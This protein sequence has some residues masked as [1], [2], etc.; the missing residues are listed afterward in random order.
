MGSGVLALFVVRSRRAPRAFEGPVVSVVGHTLSGSI[1]KSGA[2]GKFSGA[3]VLWLVTIWRDLRGGRQNYGKGR[4][5][6][7]L[8]SG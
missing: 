7:G 5:E 8:L 1:T 3:S 4:G 2:G 6:C